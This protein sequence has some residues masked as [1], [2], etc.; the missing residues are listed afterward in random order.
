MPC[1]T[2]VRPLWSY[3]A[4]ALPPLLVVERAGRRRRRWDRSPT[5]RQT[6]WRRS[7]QPWRRQKEN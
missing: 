4:I 3:V 1:I 6:T 7:R 2:I 5:C